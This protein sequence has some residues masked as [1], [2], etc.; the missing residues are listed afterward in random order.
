MGIVAT[1]TT[2]REI[3]SVFNFDRETPFTG[4]TSDKFTATFLY[5]EGIGTGATFSIV[6]IPN[7][8]YVVSTSFPLEGFWTVFIDVS[9]DGYILETHQINVLVSNSTAQISVQNKGNSL[10][11]VGTLNF[12]GD[13]VVTE[14]AGVAT[15]KI[16]G[17]PPAPSGTSPASSEVTTTI[18]GNEGTLTFVSE[19]Q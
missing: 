7:G 5:E 8:R 15:I 3:I 4:L 17:S 2:H 19:S 1:N 18:N 13:V 9:V 11:K 6:E 14:E 10:N 16:Q 12:S